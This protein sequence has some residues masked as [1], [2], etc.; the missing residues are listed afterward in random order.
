MK[1][2]YSAGA[3]GYGNGWAWHRFYKFPNLPVVTKS[4]TITKKVGYPFAIIKIGDS[5]Y[6]RVKLHNIGLYSWIDWFKRTLDFNNTKITISIAGYDDEIEEMVKTINWLK[7]EN[8]FGI[9]LNYSCPNVKGFKNKKIPYSTI[10]L[11]LK[12]NCGQNPH[13]YDLFKIRSIRVNSVPC[14][15]GGKSGKAAQKDNWEFIRRFNKEGLHISGSS[16]LSHNDIKYLEEYC[17]CE[18]IGIGS[19]I[20]IKPKLIEELI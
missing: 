15:F 11:H 20:L 18:E 19:T 2:F 13:D 12:L 4:L 14:F 5:I 3:M 7:L 17:G 1:F 10:P 8:I 6:N 9:E 16:F